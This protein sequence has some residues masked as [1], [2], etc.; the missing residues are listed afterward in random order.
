[1]IT[2]ISKKVG[3]DGRYVAELAGLST[4]TKPDGKI[5]GST[6]YA[7]DINCKYMYNED[8]TSDDKWELI[9]GTEPET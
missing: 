7:M 8:S 1:M 4:D 5:N 6:F 3:L 9:E 2:I